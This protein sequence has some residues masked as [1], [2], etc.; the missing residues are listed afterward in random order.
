MKIQKR[1]NNYRQNEDYSNERWECWICLRWRRI[2][3]NPKKSSPCPCI[4]WE[5]R[6]IQSFGRKLC[7]YHHRN[8]SKGSHSKP[9]NICIS[10]HLSRSL[11]CLLTHTQIMW[12][13][14]RV[15]GY[16]RK[17]SSFAFGN[18][19][20]GS[21]NKCTLYNG[22]WFCIFFAEFLRRFD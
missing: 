15:Y 22:G 7:Y 19:F 21:A 4:W 16:M 2:R 8:Y 9:N 10:P 3:S 12:L 13:L 14:Q 6:R 1:M 18:T 5:I 11:S 20:Y 17:P